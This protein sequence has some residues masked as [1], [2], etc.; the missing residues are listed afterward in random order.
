MA[1]I[2]DHDRPDTAA[3]IQHLAL[4]KRLPL[5]VGV[6]MSSTWK[7]DLTD[8]LCYGFDPTDNTLNNLAKI[9]LDRQQEN[10]REVFENL[11]K[12]GYTLPSEA[13][14]PILSKFHLEQPFALSDLL[15]E[16]GYGLGDPPAGKILLSAGCTYATIEPAEV[17]EAAHQSGGVCLLAHPGRG[18]GFYTFD[19]EELDEFRKEAPIDGLEVYYPIHT[20]EQT[21]MYL[22]YA[23]RHSLLISAG[24]DSHSPDKPPI[25]YRA[26]LVR[27]LLERVGIQIKP[28]NTP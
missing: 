10:T 1:A 9:L 4:D 7:G 16:H 18:D 8:M 17:V 2:T 24:S 26:E 14:P 23:Q 6:E 19:L 22:D 12:E 20:T 27:G 15:K 13:L 21:A 25:K 28:E 3:E 5:L 11:Q